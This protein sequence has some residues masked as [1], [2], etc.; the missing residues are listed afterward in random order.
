MVLRQVSERSGRTTK[1]RTENYSAIADLGAA[2][3]PRETRMIW[4]A[5]QQISALRDRDASR[6]SRGNSKHPTTI[7]PST[8][9]LLQ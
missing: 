4:M 1:W 9:E 2:P 7:A 8:L 5:L 6:E 3:D